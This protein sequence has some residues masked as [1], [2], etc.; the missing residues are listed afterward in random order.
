MRVLVDTNVLLR[1]AVP[2]HQLSSTAVEA[3]R[4]LRTNGHD[5]FVVPQ[6]VYEFWTAATRT[7]DYNGLGLS[8]DDTERV[9]NEFFAVVRLLRDERAIYQPCGRW[10]TVV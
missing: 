3:L 4:Q 7:T 9:I 10:N 2:S 8:T 5:L 6:N 1:V